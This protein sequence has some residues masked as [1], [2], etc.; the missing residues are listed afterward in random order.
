MGAAS[1]PWKAF[2]RFVFSPALQDTIRAL[3]SGGISRIALPNCSQCHYLCPASLGDGSHMVG[4]F[5]RHLLQ[6]PLLFC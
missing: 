1:A 2:V 6:Y 4:T 5:G 3:Y